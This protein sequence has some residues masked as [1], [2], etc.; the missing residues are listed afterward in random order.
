ML[1]APAGALDRNRRSP[2]APGGRS[3]GAPGGTCP[4]ASQVASAGSAAALTNKPTAAPQVVASCCR[5]AVAPNR[6]VP[7]VPGA[8]TAIV[9]HPSDGTGVV[10]RASKRNDR[11]RY[12][13]VNSGLITRLSDVP[14]RGLPR[15]RRSGVPA[16]GLPR[17]PRGGVP[18]GSAAP[19]ESPGARPPRSE[20]PGAGAVRSPPGGDLRDACTAGYP[21]PAGFAARLA[22]GVRRGTSSGA[23]T[24]QNQRLLCG[25]G[26]FRGDDYR[27][28]ESLS[29]PFEPL[30]RVGVQSHQRAA[31]AHQCT[32]FRVQF[33]SGRSLDRIL[34][35][36]SPGAQAP[37]GHTD[38]IGVEFHQHPISGGEI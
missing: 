13:W 20:S 21:L 23:D 22:P 33:H 32:G 25:T 28:G 5:A 19:S 2:G 16:R 15:R 27:V 14:A 24:V 4:V 6:T 26:T 31:R 29:G 17:R 36:G 12:R 10:R 1:P 11:S 37:S 8:G 18:A 38:G 30:G 35:T 7:P 9:A 34:T 3:P